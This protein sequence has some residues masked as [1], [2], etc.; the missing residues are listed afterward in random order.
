VT[1]KEKEAE[2]FRTQVEELR[3]KALKDADEVRAKAQKELEAV[4]GLSAA[5][6]REMALRTAEAEMRHELALRYRELEQRAKEEAEEK[7]RKYIALAVQ[8]LAVDVVSESTVSAVSL[9]NDEMKGRLIGREGRNIRAIEQA[10]GV[11]LIIDDTPEA[12][13]ISCFDPIRREIARIALEKLI[14]DGR[15]HPG[16]IEETVEKARQEVDQAISEAG[17]QAVFESGVRGLNPD[18]IKLLGRLRYRTSYGGNVLKHAVEVSLLS[19]MLAAEVGVNVE[20][21]KT[22]GLL[23][24]IGKALS[25]EVEGPH[26]EIGGE[27]AAKYGISEGVRRAIME[28]HDEEKGSVEA[29]LVVAADAMSAARP[30]ARKDNLQAYVKRLEALENLVNSFPGVEKSFAIQ[31]GREVRIMVKPD[32][33]DDLAASQM[34][35]DI[36]KKI[37]ENLVFPGQIKVVV[38]R[39]TRA[40]EFAR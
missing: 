9:P 7:A 34:A 14:Q 27:L 33:I 15:I 38:I 26:A 37:Q 18:L 8:R 20:V 22:A 5:E 35:R 29:F 17:Q 10:T 28:H 1:T 3:A 16:R 36:S 23:H 39:E 21:A 40:V 31:A 13:T 32:Q 12:V 11:D 19:G 6:A 25:H 2:G 4:S 30:G 24:D